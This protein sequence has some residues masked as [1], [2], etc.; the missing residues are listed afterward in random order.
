MAREKKP[1]D[2]QCW[3]DLVNKG[4]WFMVWE[5][6]WVSLFTWRPALILKWPQERLEAIHWYTAILKRPDLADHCDFGAIRYRFMNY[7]YFWGGVLALRPDLAHYCDWGQLDEHTRT[8][9]LFKH[10]EL[11]LSIP[12]EHITGEMWS[13]ALVR[14]ERLAEHCQ[15]EKLSESDWRFL[16]DIQPSLVSH[17]VPHENTDWEMIFTADPRML[18]TCPVEKLTGWTLCSL[19]IYHPEFAYRADFSTISPQEWSEL[20]IHRPEFAD[21]CDFAC[22]SASEWVSL[23]CSKPA[24]ASKCDWTLLGG[25]DWESL[26]GSQPKFA[27][28]CD[29]DKLTPDNWVRLFVLQPELGKYCKIWDQF[30]FHNWQGIV[31]YHGDYAWRCPERMRKGIDGRAWFWEAADAW[32][33]N[34]E[35]Q[36]VRRNE[37]KTPNGG[38]CYP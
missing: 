10:P 6:N 29:W 12:E 26:L 28:Y 3:I 9:I 37:G 25:E 15:W 33:E 19:L 20:L 31:A 38:G 32:H 2:L 18:A 8:G 14:E 1:Y 13:Q 36:I 23:L 35:L 4:Q 17:Y 34:E 5:R 30:S 7:G 21:R 16:L 22:F 11:I 24:F 27:K